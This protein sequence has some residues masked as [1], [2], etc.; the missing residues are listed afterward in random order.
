VFMTSTYETD[1]KQALYP[2]LATDIT[3][4]IAGERNAIANLSNV[5]ALL[6]VALTDINWV[7]FYLMDTTRG[8]LV[9]GPFQGKPACIRID[10]GKGV[11][12]TAATRRETMVVADV[13]A[14]PGH[15]ACDS[16]S[17]SEVVVPIVQDGR[18]IGVLDIDSPTRNRFDACDAQGLES[19][20]Q[21]IVAGCD[22][23]LF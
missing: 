10:M 16:A 12:G 9:L 22:F 7:G 4:L 15:I 3:H 14:F 1:S 21:I 8:Q 11:C 13:D 20:V 17:K 18:M 6:N 23:N 2:R 19:V 5:S